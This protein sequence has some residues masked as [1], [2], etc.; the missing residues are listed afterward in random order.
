MAQDGVAAALSRALAAVQG[1]TAALD[2]T[3]QLL[4]QLLQTDAAH[5]HPFARQLLPGGGLSPAVLPQ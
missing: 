3:C 2:P 5:H 4:A 1:D